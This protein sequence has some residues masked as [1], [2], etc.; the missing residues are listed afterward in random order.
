MMRGSSAMSRSSPT[1][2]NRSRRRRTP[3]SSFQI[4]RSRSTEIPGLINVWE[5]SVRAT[6]GFLTEDDIVALRPLVEAALDDEALELWVLLTDRVRGGRSLAA[7][8]WRATVP[9]LAHAPTGNS[10]EVGRRRRRRRQHGRVGR[11]SANR[12][13]LR[14]P[15]SRASARSTSARSTA[16]HPSRSRSL[17]WP[18][19]PPTNPSPRR[20]RRESMR[21]M[22]ASVRIDKWL[23]AARFFKT[24][25]AAT[26]AV[27]GGR[28]RVNGERVKPAKHVHAADI[29]EVR[30]GEVD[31]TINVLEVADKRGSARVAAGLFEETAESM[32]E[33][34]RS[35]EERRLSRPPGTVVGGRR[36]TKQDRRRIE[37]LRRKR[38]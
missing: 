5:R 16:A 13:S 20:K 23:W 18:N 32:A 3:A 14:R 10:S 34:Q 33:R 27:L 11:G 12:S 25:A 21:S 24:R 35:A 26:E 22:T 2:S 19:Q 8:R 37:A 38:G 15:S 28:V 17:T 31:W 7:R 6:H 1:S 9:T 30:V 29:V 36:P 4:R